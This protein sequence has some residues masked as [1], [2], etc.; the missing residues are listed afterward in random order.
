MDEEK[1]REKVLKKFVEEKAYSSQF[2]LE[3]AEKFAD[4]ATITT[5]GDVVI[6]CKCSVIDRV[7]TVAIARFL[8]NLL[9][10]EIKAD[11][12]AEVTSEEVARYAGID[13]SVASARLKDLTDGGLLNKPSRGVFK[14]RSPSHAGRWIDILHKKYIKKG[15]LKR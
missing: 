3:L 10:D 14:V 15:G 1:L 7:A 13:K 4:I 5:A 6:K 2:V 9:K 11:I 12:P 8:G